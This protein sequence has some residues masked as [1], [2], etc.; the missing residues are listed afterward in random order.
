M[1]SYDDRKQRLSCRFCCRELVKED[2]YKHL[3]L[4]QKLTRRQGRILAFEL[5]KYWAMSKKIMPVGPRPATN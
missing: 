4:C 3:T 2:I 5:L 1:R